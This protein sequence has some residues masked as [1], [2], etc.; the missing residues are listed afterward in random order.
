MQRR[1]FLFWAS[2][3]MFRLGE[4]LEIDGL[5]RLAAATINTA[6]ARP[7]DFEL[8]RTE[9]GGPDQ[10]EEEPA[11]AVEEDEDDEGEPGS[12][13]PQRRAR[14]GRPPSKWLRS[15]CAEEIRIFLEKIDPPEAG[16]S[17]M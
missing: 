4:V 6:A 9:L 15:L 3:G 10:C 7:S 8:R 1:R 13:E 5:D 12:P 17:G 14:H 2:L 16:V 11:E